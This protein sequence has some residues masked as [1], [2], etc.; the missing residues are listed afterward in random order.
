MTSVLVF[1]VLT[2]FGSDMKVEEYRSAPMPQ[3]T[4]VSILVAAKRAKLVDRGG[5]TIFPYCDR[6]DRNG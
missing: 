2:G 5:R 3:A 1:M 4:C 6:S